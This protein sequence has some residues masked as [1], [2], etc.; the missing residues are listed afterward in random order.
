MGIFFLACK[1]E[2]S[3]GGAAGE[4]QT[5]PISKGKEII[6]GE[7][8]LYEPPPPPPISYRLPCPASH[9]SNLQVVIA[10]LPKYI[11]CQLPQISIFDYQ[12]RWK[13]AVWTPVVGMMIKHKTQF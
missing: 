2:F 1:C 13:Y 5:P 8:H 6:P 10:L 9:H 11:R 12:N 7:T 4:R 3:P